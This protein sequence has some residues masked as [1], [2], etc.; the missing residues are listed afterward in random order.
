MYSSSVNT[1]N[2]LLYSLLTQLVLLWFP[3]CSSRLTLPITGSA[4]I[5]ISFSQGAKQDLHLRHHLRSSYSQTYNRGLENLFV[6]TKDQFPD[7]LWDLVGEDDN[8]K[9]LTHEVSSSLGHIPFL[10]ATAW[11]R[12]LICYPHGT[13]LPRQRP[14]T[15]LIS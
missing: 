11:S 8:V 4:F 9:G 6:L 10:F 7:V 13:T 2:S 12:T 14:Q 1:S 3:A 15:A 5:V